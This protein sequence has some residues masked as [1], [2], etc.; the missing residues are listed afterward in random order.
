M[1]RPAAPA[2]ELPGYTLIRLLG[3]GGFADVYL[4]RQRNLDRE[5]AV[6]VLLVA[7]PSPEAAARFK[8]E[9]TV[10]AR[11]SEHHSNIVP[12]YDA[13]IAPDGRPYLVMQYCPKPDLAKRYKSESFVI[14]E[15]LTIGVQLAGAVESAHQQGILHR[16]IKPANVLTTRSGRPALAD[17]GIA[18]TTAAAD[19][20]DAVGVSIPWSPPELLADEP[21]GDRRSDVYSLTATLYTLL[22]GRSPLELPGRSNKQAD[23]LGRVARVVPPPT[24]HPDAPASLERL[25]CRGLAK[26]PDQR[27]PSAQ[28]L[29]D[30]LQRIQA[31]IGCPVT[32]LDLLT[33][34]LDAAAAALPDEQ[35]DRTR[36]RPL[37]IRAQVSAV[38]DAAGT[39]SRPP[40]GPADRRPPSPS[41]P[42]IERTQ[43]RSKPTGGAYLDAPQTPTTPATAPMATPVMDQSAAAAGP[44]VAFGALPSDAAAEPVTRRRWPLLVGAA[45]LVLGAG[46]TWL[47][48]SGGTTP[49]PLPVTPAGP[50][51]STALAVVEV[52]PPPADLI[53][54]ATPEGLTFSWSNPDPQPGDSYDWRRSDLTEDEPVSR[55]TDPTVSIPGVQQGCI[56]VVLVRDNGGSSARPATGCVGQ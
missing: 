18:V 1:K 8:A 46:L 43:V 38:D 32:P 45:V 47:V 48:L 53:G 21:K 42:A 25:L 12:V 30:D 7:D 20:P 24:G 10:M 15:V 19:D 37:V 11:L 9:G 26:D 3:G 28:A 27:Y 16:D 51:S 34:N 41:E 22:A 17:F 2:P 39:R 33:E 29:A 31:E 5:V 56:E 40:I 50:P 49:P 52:V 44:A 4:Y 55:V 35:R 13:A 6:K 14:S 23:L 54:L 36:I